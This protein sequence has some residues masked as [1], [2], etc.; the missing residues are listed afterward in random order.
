MAELHRPGTSTFDRIGALLASPALYEL[1][2]AVP[3]PDPSAGV[4]LATT[5]R[6]W[7]LFGALLS[8][9]GSARRVE[10]SWRTRSSGTT[11]A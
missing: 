8:V 4:G 6:S 11:S 1:A 9:Y 10:W 5:P 2:D 7:V 3:M